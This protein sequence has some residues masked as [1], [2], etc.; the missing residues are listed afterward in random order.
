MFDYINNNNITESQIFYT[1]KCNSKCGACN[2]SKSGENNQELTSNQWKTVFINLQN[3]GIKTVKLMGGEPTEQE[4]LAILLDHI[5]FVA[6]ETDIRLALL[7]NSKWDKA[8]WFEKLCSSDLFA[9][10]ASVDTIKNETICHDSLEKSQ[11][12]Y[13]ML[14]DLQ[15]RG[16]IPLLAANVVISR[17][18]IAELPELITLLSN[19]GLFVNLCPIQC[20]LEE[21]KY[22][23]EITEYHFR[24]GQHKDMLTEA[25]IMKI[26]EVVN[27]I[28]ELQSNGCKVAVPHE[29]LIDINK[30]GLYGGTWKCSQL[31]QLRIDSDGTAMICNEFKGQKETLPNLSQPIT[32]TDKW[33]QDF[34][35]YWYDER[36]KYSCQCYW[37]CFLQAEKNIEINSTEFGFYDNPKLHGIGVNNY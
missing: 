37:S 22:N 30:Y 2:L 27:E 35:K 32:D 14:K 11:I 17:R 24:K 5:N 29:Y 26:N 7:S 6:N 36:P 10:Y 13:K 1:R 19:E 18:N 3:L 23:G 34:I 33:S 25:D 16:T 12:G 8:K 4:D 20:Y 15:K 31:S 28:I 21:P 9:Y